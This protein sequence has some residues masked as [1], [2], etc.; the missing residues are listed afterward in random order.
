[1]SKTPNTH[2]RIDRRTLADLDYFQKLAMETALYPKLHGREYVVLGLV[3]EAGELANVRKKV[4]RDGV[5]RD[6]LLKEELGDV[7]WYIAAVCEEY[8][9]DMSDVAACTIEKLRDRFER[10]QIKDR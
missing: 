3:G 5:N 10:G 7:M 6:D 1:M 8:E 2:S 4:L 9:W